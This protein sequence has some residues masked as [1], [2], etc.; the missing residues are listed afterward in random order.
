MGPLLRWASPAGRRIT[1]SQNSLASSSASASSRRRMERRE[2]IE[3]LRPL[4]AVASPST[5]RVY[6]N[7]EDDN[8][9]IVLLGDQLYDEIMQFTSLPPP[10]PPPLPFRPS[11]P[12]PY[13]YCQHMIAYHPCNI[14][15][16]YNNTTLAVNHRVEAKRE[17]CFGGNDARGGKRIVK[18]AT[19]ERVSTRGARGLAGMGSREDL[20]PLRCL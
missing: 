16:T 8:G 18:Q 14:L 11:S 13:L 6:P 5:G 9:V 10:V 3:P 4:A 2:K 19:R 12:S 17:G 1:L 7:A 15:T 20:P